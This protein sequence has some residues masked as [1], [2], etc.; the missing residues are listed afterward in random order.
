MSADLWDRIR[1]AAERLRAIDSDDP[2]SEAEHVA[3][4]ALGLRSRG[5]L[6]LREAGLSA[7]ES[8]AFERLLQRRLAREPLQYVLGS[9]PFRELDLVVGPGVL[10]PRPETEVLVERVLHWIEDA[11][12]AAG[13]TPARS[14]PESA[15]GL[16]SG[17]APVAE[18][19]PPSAIRTDRPA[20]S[21]WIVD[22]GTGSGAILLGLL[23][24]LPEWRGVGI[25]RSSDALDYA[26]RN[27]DRYPQLRA[28]AI[29]VCADLLAPLRPVAELHDS[30]RVAAIVSNPPYIPTRE[31]GSLA[32]EVRDHEPRIALDGGEDG[33]VVV[34][35]I[36]DQ[37]SQVL[38]PG[39][40][41]AFELSLGQP[42]QVATLVEESGFEVLEA[43]HDLTGRERGVIA[44]KRSMI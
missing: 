7:S 39:G 14:G 34:R 40:L 35:A 10:I 1:D 12:Q 44:R 18:S 37:S 2:R 25:D 24:R 27:L 16:A 4:H 8:D 5:Q 30:A 19:V 15:A 3:V 42:R 21:R 22:V 28:R 26:R 38:E 32:P 33:L 43:F 9:V 36:V 31:V 41:L 23:N 11:S 13:P 29:L 20:G 6:L 17:A